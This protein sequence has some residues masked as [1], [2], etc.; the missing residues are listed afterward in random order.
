MLTSVTVLLLTAASFIIYD[1]ITYRQMMV[2]SLSTVAAIIAGH[3]GPAVAAQDQTQASNILGSLHAAPNIEAAALYDSKGKLLAVY[4]AQSPPAAFPQ[5]PESPSHRFKHGQLW[6]FQPVTDVH[7]TVGTLYLASELRPLFERLRLYGAIALLVLFGSVL[8]TLALSQALQRRITEP[9]LA[10]ANTARLVSEH[11]D[12]SVRAAKAGNDELGQLTESFNQMLMSI[13]QAEKARSFL[14]AIVESSDAAIVG[15]DLAGTVVSWNAAAERMFGYT[16]SEIIGQPITRIVAPDR[17][18]EEPRLLLDMRQG[19]IRYYETV[20]VRK[21]GKPINVS[22]I[23]SPVKNR[24]GKIIGLSSIARDIT[25]WKLTEQEVAESRAR[26]SNIINSA[27]DAIIIVDAEQQ[28]R[29]FN[30]AAEKMF[31][32]SREEA[33]GQ[34]LGRFIPER[35]RHVHHEHVQR[36]GSTGATGRAMGHL[37]PLSGLRTD[38]EEFPIEASISQTEFNGQKIYTVILRDITARQH[39]ERLLER[40]TAMLREQTEQIR[41]MNL[42]LEERVAQRTAELTG[43]NQELEAFTYSVAHDLRAPLRHID[44]FS[45]ILREEYAAV[46]PP[47][48]ERYLQSIRNS[49]QHMSRLVDDL[50]NLARVGRQELKREPTSLDR[51]VAEVMTEFKDEIKG[52]QIEWKIQPLPTIECD[53]G[54]MRLFFVN[55]LSNALKY[56]RPRPIAEIEIGSMEVK[57]TKVV[58]VRDNGVGFNMKY[59]DKLFRVFQRLHRADDFEGTGVGLATVERIVQRHGGRVWA[60]AAVDKGATFYLTIKGLK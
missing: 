40:Q 33:I 5:R 2:R 51:L 6:L 20:R 12:F 36:F 46:L 24:D 37:Q 60:E 54:L 18:E 48:C 11:G 58:Y 8:V 44:A 43:A 3:S 19:V 16:A 1:F 34:P 42:E 9:L 22:L 31:R 45:K 59:A 10:L 27:M 13:E 52:R 55:L 49:S 50:L 41:R 35:L 7:G 30:A 39:A 14:A 4:P 47:E 29:L 57:A 23:A 15:K 25:E 17:P 28:I 56:T 38:G 53:P 32:C 26:L 21:D